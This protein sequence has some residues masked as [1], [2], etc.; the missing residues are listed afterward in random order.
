MGAPQGRPALQVDRDLL[1]GPDD[2][3]EQ[4]GEHFCGLGRAL[5]RGV[6]MQPDE[7]L[8]VRKPVGEQMR[9]AGDQRG[10]P[11][12]RHSVHGTYGD[13]AGRTGGRDEPVQFTVT[14]GERRHVT[15]KGAQRGDGGR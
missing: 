7:H 6:G 13:A 9:G 10:L 11:H 14:P 1:R 4:S 12:P 5:P 8:A 2:S 3:G 15:G